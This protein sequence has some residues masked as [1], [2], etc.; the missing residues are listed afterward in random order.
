MRRFFPLVIPFVLL[1]A[2]ASA[3]LGQGAQRVS[4]PA[5]PGQKDFFTD[6]AGIIGP[7]ERQAINEI[8]G[9][10]LTEQ[11]VPVFVVTIVSMA[12]H[13]AAEYTVERYAYELFNNWGIGSHQRNYGMLLVV[14]RDD[15]RARIELGSDWGYS[16]NEGAKQLMD[17]IITPAFKQ[18]NFSAGIL[19]GVKG[20]DA[21]A[22]GLA[23][24]QPKQP[25]W[26]LP[27]FLG[28]F[29]LIIGIIVNLFRTGRS[30][31]GWALIAGLGVMIFMIL[32]GMASSRGSGGGFGGGSSGG[33]GASGS[34]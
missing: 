27:L 21:L 12:S 6:E 17:T 23:L 8:A 5:K 31:W 20:L 30:G 4:F 2:G 13:G 24:P 7:A 34:W 9:R 3:A 25:W 14:S 33:G 29:A 18:G 10:L 28:G 11:K 19:D 22:R 26:V 15:H 16:H 32:R 1:L